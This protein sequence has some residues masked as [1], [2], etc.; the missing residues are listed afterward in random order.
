HTKGWPT[1]TT[2]LMRWAKKQGA[3]T[4][5]AHSANGLEIDAAAASKR[6]MAALN[7]S[8]DGKLTR[9]QAARGLLPED[10]DAIDANKDGLLTLGELTASHQRISHIQQWSTVPSPEGFAPHIDPS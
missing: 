10:F 4:G 3:C 6:L 7:T 9:E 5:Y 1:W 2:P 8:K